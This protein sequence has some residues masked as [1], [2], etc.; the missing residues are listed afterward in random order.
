[1]LVEQKKS[2]EAAVNSKLGG[3]IA[4]TGSCGSQLLHHSGSLWAGQVIHMFYLKIDHCNYTDWIWHFRT[5]KNQSATVVWTI[6]VQQFRE[7]ETS[8]PFFFTASVKML[9]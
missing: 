2:Q 6:F 5:C 7:S 4:L 1:M 8:A 3:F 9:D